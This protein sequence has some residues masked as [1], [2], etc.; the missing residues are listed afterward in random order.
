M[1]VEAMPKVLVVDDDDDIVWMISAVLR[2]DYAVLSASD[3]KSA[4]HALEGNDVAGVIA[5][6]MMPGMTGVELLDRSL[7]LRPAAARI[8]IT[9]SDRVNVLKDAVNRARVH[10]FLSKPL[11]LT[12]LPAILSDAIR[13]A[14]LEAENR[15]L[16]KE[17][18]F[19]NEQLARVNE[20]LEA[21]VRQRTQ[22]LRAAIEKLEEMALRDGLTGLFNHRYFQ[23]A[24]EAEL[25]RARRHNHSVGLIFL[26][27][28]H[29]KTYNDKHGHPAGD[30]LLRRL[31]EVLVGGRESGLP[32]Q[33]RASDIV[34]RYGGEEFVI[35]LPATSFEGTLVKAERIRGLIGDFPFD[36]ASAQPLGRVSVSVGVAAF[37]DHGAEKQLLIDVADQQL[38]RAKRA[39]RNRVCGPGQDPGHE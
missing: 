25:S 38:Y 12:E 26:D 32:M 18:A 13:E 2:K 15:V 36:H 19:K 14:Q 27:V 35:V 30:R 7:E 8:L 5:D 17:L 39:G 10:R 21:E 1:Q 23:E 31:A 4:V 16:V 22:E 11:R 6:H 3:G 20:G 34:A 33:T 9:A 28:D 37:P 24:L 29:F